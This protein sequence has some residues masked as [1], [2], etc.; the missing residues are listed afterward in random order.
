[1]LRA[2]VMLS[3]NV[4]TIGCVNDTPTRAFT[5]D[6]MSLDC[7]DANPA[8]CHPDLPG[9]T[10]ATGEAV[11]T[12]AEPSPQ[13]DPKQRPWRCRSSCRVRSAI[14]TSAIM[15]TPTSGAQQAEMWFGRMDANSATPVLSIYSDDTG[16]APHDSE[17]SHYSCRPD[18]LGSDVLDASTA[19][20]GQQRPKRGG[21]DQ[22]IAIYLVAHSRSLSMLL[23]ESVIRCSYS[24]AATDRPA[25]RASI[26]TYRR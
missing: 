25:N 21:R 11:R 19:L 17:A 3:H 14:R 20:W 2:T 7:Q 10:G 24:G 15:A 12:S 4:T 13:D 18:I 1:V 6:W 26:R 8:L 22:V 23:T 5:T 16:K 9:A